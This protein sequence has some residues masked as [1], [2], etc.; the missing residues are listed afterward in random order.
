VWRYLALKCT[1]SGREAIDEREEGARMTRSGKALGILA[2][3]ATLLTMVAIALTRAADNADQRLGATQSPTPNA[4]D[5]SA[6]NRRLGRGVNILGYDPSWVSPVN[7][8]M[9][10][11]HF[12]L[13]KQ[14]GFDSVRI[15]LHPLRDTRVGPN[16]RLPDAWFHTL[17]WA[18]SQALAHHLLVVLDLHESEAISNDPAGNRQRFL[19]EW[20][21]IADRYRGSPNEVVFELLNE[22]NR[23]LTPALWNQYLG[24][25]LAV[26][27]ASNPNRTVIIGP[28]RSNSIRGLDELTLPPGD[29]N[30]I[31]TIHYYEPFEF[32]HQG[33]PWV[34]R[35]DQVGVHWTG[36]RAEMQAVRRDFDV[37]RRWALEHDRPLY[38]G[39]FGAYE[40][41]DL[42][43]RVAWTE[44]VAREAERRGWSWSYWQFDSDF[45]AYDI[46]G[47]QW[48]EPIRNALVPTSART[49]GPESVGASR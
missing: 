13:I 27:R 44:F 35:Q 9:R 3:L 47:Q 43:D 32:T 22:P 1:I 24:D 28:G 12:R 37:A 19:S 2:W 40:A 18:V 39:E 8:R 30:V 21:Q 16:E 31:V 20:R 15:N 29:R 33:A 41:G 5:A 23:K 49:P 11:H 45:I 7:A 34:G 25:A 48:V 42:A 26:I 4:A 14:A 38:L 10:A 46:P 36:T 6:L 17:D